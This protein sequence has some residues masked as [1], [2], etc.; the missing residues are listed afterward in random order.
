MTASPLYD[1]TRVLAHT[2]NECLILPENKCRT[3]QSQEVP[4]DAGAVTRIEVVCVPNFP[5]VV[6]WEAEHHEHIG[7]T[8]VSAP[9]DRS[10]GAT[11]STAAV[12]PE[13][14]TVHATNLAN[15]RGFVTLFVGCA[16]EP[17]IGAPF[18]L[19]RNGLPTKTLRRLSKDLNKDDRR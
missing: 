13:S 14:V 11:A 18:P 2:N 17:A 3:I 10:G 16:A 1:T 8:L 19:S 12:E 15:A 6:G 7:L 5:Y 4:L 9:P